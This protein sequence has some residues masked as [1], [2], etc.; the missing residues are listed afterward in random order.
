MQLLCPIGVLQD[1]PIHV[2]TDS[3]STRALAHSSTFHGRAKHIEVLIIL[4]VN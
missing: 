2:F 4:F 1:C 3:Q